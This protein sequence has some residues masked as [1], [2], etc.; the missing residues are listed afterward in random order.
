[1]TTE[2]PVWFYRINDFKHKFIHYLKLINERPERQE[3]IHLINEMILRS[4]CSL[5]VQLVRAIR[6]YKLDEGL[7]EPL[8]RKLLIIAKN[9]ELI[10]NSEDWLY[11]ID[12]LNVYEQELNPKKREFY[13]DYIV[14]IYQNKFMNLYKDLTSRFPIKPE[15]ADIFEKQSNTKNPKELYDDTLPEYHHNYIGIT[16][17]SYQIILNYLRSKKCIKKVWLQGSRVFRIPRKGS[18]IDLIL[19]C[20]LEEQKN[21]D[22]EL[23]ELAIPYKLDAKNIN[24]NSHFLKRVAQLGTKLIYSAD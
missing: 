13:L 21:I 3:Q 10:S 17:K 8:P 20:P 24:T 15:Y 6:D 14:K 7:Y 9:E 16:E 18:D 22:K 1:M 5:F 12:L 19:D 4:M 23:K 2:L 11:F